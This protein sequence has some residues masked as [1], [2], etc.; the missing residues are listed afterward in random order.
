[1]PIRGA[2]LAVRRAFCLR[3]TLFRRRRP[4]SRRRGVSRGQTYNVGPASKYIHFSGSA[5]ARLQPSTPG[6]TTVPPNYLPFFSIG[7]AIPTSP[8]PRQ[9]SGGAQGTVSLRDSLTWVRGNTRR[10][11][12]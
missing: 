6:L 2:F 12:A 5:S 9:H 1:M 8:G 3:V 7:R 10:G 4:V 11:L